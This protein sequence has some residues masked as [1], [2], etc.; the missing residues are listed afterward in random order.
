MP[1]RVRNT[2]LEGPWPSETQ[3]VPSGTRRG[4]GP[5]P[6]VRPTEL[7]TC[8]MATGP[9]GEGT[10]AAAL[11]DVEADAMAR[12]WPQ[13]VAFLPPPSQGPVEITRRSGP[14]RPLLRFAQTEQVTPSPR[15]QMHQQR[16]IWYRL[17]HFPSLPLPPAFQGVDSLNVTVSQVTREQRLPW[18][19]GNGSR[20]L[21]RTHW[22]GGRATAW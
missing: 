13:P 11:T 12:L 1:E 20:Q 22:Q 5:A 7:D 8:G 9:P 3:R 17:T 6:G 14:R 2:H 18:T 16:L 4:L 19:R 15:T 21:D 10:A